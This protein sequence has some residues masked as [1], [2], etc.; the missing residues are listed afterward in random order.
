MN[1]RFFVCLFFP[2]TRAASRGICVKILNHNPAMLENFAFL[3]AEALA[4]AGI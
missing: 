1:F 3:P 4:Q 2:I